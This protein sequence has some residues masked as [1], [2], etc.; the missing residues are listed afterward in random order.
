MRRRFLYGMLFT[1]AVCGLI[2]CGSDKDSE[3]DVASYDPSKAVSISNFI[4]KDG[5][6]GQ[7]LVVFGENFGN[8]TSKVTVTVGGKKAVLVNVKGNS[9]YCLVPAQ[10][11][12]GEVQVIVDDAQI[13]TQIAVA[14]EKFDYKRKMVGRSLVGYR[15]E[16]DD[17]RWKEGPFSIAAGFR[18][19]GCLVFDPMNYDKLYVVYD[20]ADIQLIDLKE[21]YVKTIISKSSFDDKRLRLIDFTADG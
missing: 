17:Q 1:I 12:S 20:G 18:N 8:D 19:D 13:G 10:A 5:S 9:L 15:N 2:S 16:R 11:Y 21:E 7:R 3:N 4:P 14:A 6:V